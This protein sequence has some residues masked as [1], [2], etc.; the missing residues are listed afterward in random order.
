MP[1]CQQSC[2]LLS[3]LKGLFIPLEHTIAVLLAS[4]ILLSPMMVP[5]IRN[6]LETTYIHQGLDVCRAARSHQCRP[7]PTPAK[8]LIKALP[9]RIASLSPYSYAHLLDL[10]FEALYWVQG[11]YGSLYGLRHGLDRTGLLWDHCIREPGQLEG[12]LGDRDHPREA[13]ETGLL[14]I[15]IIDNPKRMGTLHVA[16]A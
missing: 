3:A 7:T 14:V 12:E 16:R 9:I 11:C 6:L 4:A 1:T 13:I 5:H 2:R 8:T 10:P 15:T